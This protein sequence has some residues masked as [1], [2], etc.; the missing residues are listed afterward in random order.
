MDY[1]GV[2]ILRKQTYILLYYNIIGFILQI[3]IVY[4]CTQHT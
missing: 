4:N 2:P 1:S 3:L